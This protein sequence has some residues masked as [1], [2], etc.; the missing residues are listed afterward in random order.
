M[1]QADLGLN[2]AAKRT[3]KREFLD[4]MNRVLPWADLVELITPFAPEGRRGRPPFAVE[5]MLRLHFMQQWFGLSDPATEEA[6]HDVP[7]Y[8][9]FAGL[10]NWTTR[11]LD[12]STILRFRNL[13]EKHKLV[14]QMLASINDML[15]NKGLML[16]AGTVVDAT[17]IAA[18]SSTK[19]ASGERDP[20][21]HQTK[22]G[23]QWYFGTR[24]HIGADAES[25]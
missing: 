11:L 14:A 21:M 2:L 13:L 4:E 9:E 7:L 19:N 17:L 12:E 6:L 25:G 10:D 3:R 15:R 23:N 5:T 18:P 22:K 20:E 1:K 8:R 24:A 16:R